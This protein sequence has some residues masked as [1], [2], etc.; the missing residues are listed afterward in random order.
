MISTRVLA[1]VAAFTVGVPVVLAA[2]IPFALVQVTLSPIGLDALLFGSLFP[3]SI[4]GAVLMGL[5]VVCYALALA[6]LV[7]GGASAP[8]PIVGRNI[9]VTDGIYAHLRNPMLV[10]ITLYV[11][12]AGL[13]LDSTA[14]VGYGGL[15]WTAFFLLVNGLEEKSLERTYGA[16][17]THYCERVSRWVPRLRPYEP[18]GESPSE[19]EA[20]ASEYSGSD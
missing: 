18:S 13:W 7:A 3:V 1:R 14:V 9:L 17:Y 4:V 20:G 11:L 12:G 10:G 19:G 16:R 8:I 15:L 2:L 5:G 6:A